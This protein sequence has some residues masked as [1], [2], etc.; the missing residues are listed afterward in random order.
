MKRNA[1]TFRIKPELK[2]AY[3]KVH[4]EFWPDLA[5]AINDAGLK[6][7]STFFRKDGTIFAYLE[8]DDYE[9]AMELIRETEIYP[10]WEKFVDKFYIKD[11]PSILGPQNEML[12]EIWHQD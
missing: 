7:F 10:R 6:N 3:K 5:K 1:F 2:S 4:D 9:K 11:E 8:A 12:E